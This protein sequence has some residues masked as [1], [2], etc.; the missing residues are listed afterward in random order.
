MRRR[1]YY[2]MSHDAH[3]PYLVTSLHALR[4]V[5]DGEVVVYAW[6]Q[7]IEIVEWIAKDQRLNIVPIKN[8]P[9]YRG[10]NDQFIHKQEIAIQMEGAVD[11]CLYLDADT[12]PMKPVFTDLLDCAHSHGFLATQFNDWMTNGLTRKRI[13]RLIDRDPIVQECVRVCLA[14]GERSVNGGV[15]GCRPDSEVLRTWREWTLAVKDIFIA[16]ETVLH[17]VCVYHKDQVAVIHGYNTSAVSRFQDLPDAEVN[18][19]HFHG[20]SN[21]RP[22]KSQH[23]LNIWWP[24]FEMCKRYNVGG[25]KDWIGEIQ[26]KHLNKIEGWDG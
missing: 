12:L 8:N 5:W 13:E 19:W 15:F 7:S 3:L 22:D 26:N 17:P 1:I 11:V 16:D 18:I 25:I 23:G 9:E 6:D 10:K 14:G 4:K 2:V 20:D 21:C 24:V